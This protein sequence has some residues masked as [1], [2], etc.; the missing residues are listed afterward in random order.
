MDGERK[1]ILVVDDEPSIVKLVSV[2]LEKEGYELYTAYDGEEALSKVRDVNP[3]LIVLDVMM[4]KLDGR[5]VCARIKGNPETKQ[6]P[7]IML[8]AVGQFEEQL[9]GMEAGAD[10]Y[11]TKPFSPEALAK[12]VAEVLKKDAGFEKHRTGQERKLKTIIGIMHR[13][14][15]E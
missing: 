3:D 14:D 5:Q 11:V 9:K 2:K 6:I 12:T 10:E 15:K 8:T 7:I 4:P 1:K 13:E